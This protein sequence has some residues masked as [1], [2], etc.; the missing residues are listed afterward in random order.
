MGQ[1][2]TGVVRHVLEWNVPL[3]ILGGGGY[4]NADSARCYTAIA[5]EVVGVRLPRDIPEHDY[6]NH[7]GMRQT[8]TSGWLAGNLA[9]LRALSQLA[10]QDGDCHCIHWCQ[11]F[12]SSRSAVFY[13]LP[14][15]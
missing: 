13:G 6:L 4:H 8:H 10:V 15:I 9:A 11:F 1:A 2:Y 7:Y 5:A 3:L 14:G 12:A